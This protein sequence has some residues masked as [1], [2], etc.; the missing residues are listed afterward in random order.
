MA[1]EGALSA[2]TMQS[3]TTAMGT[4]IQPSTVGALPSKSQ[5]LVLL[6]PSGLQ[7]DLCGSEVL[8]VKME[9]VSLGFRTVPE[10]LLISGA[11]EGCAVPSCAVGAS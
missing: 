2:G 11:G 9:T 3:L 6:K 5:V 4:R 7:P 8:N 1:C 10:E